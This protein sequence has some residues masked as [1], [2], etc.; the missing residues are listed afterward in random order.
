MLS[1]PMLLFISHMFG[2]M[3]HE[4]VSIPCQP[5]PG[6]ERCCTKLNYFIECGGSDNETSVCQV[7]QN[8]LSKY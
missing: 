3:C 2:C 8:R 7:L 1:S 5:I 4:P 6:I